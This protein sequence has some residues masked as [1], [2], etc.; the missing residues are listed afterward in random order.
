MRESGKLKKAKLVEKQQIKMK[1]WKCHQQ[2]WHQFPS[3]QDP[4]AS[5]CRG[6]QVLFPSLFYYFS[7]VTIY[8]PCTLFHTSPSRHHSVVNVH[9]FFSFCF[10]FCSIPSP[11]PPPPPGSCQPWD[12]LDFLKEKPLGTTNSFKLQLDINSC[13]N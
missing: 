9:E 2:T 4:Q 5:G 7:P 11:S 8:P 12:I 1:K 10:L 13:G 6:R 3:H